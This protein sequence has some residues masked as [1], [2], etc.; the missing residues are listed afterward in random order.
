MKNIART[1]IIAS[2]SAASLLTNVN[3]QEAAV[4]DT[5]AVESKGGFLWGTVMYLPNRIFD[6]QDMVRARVRV[7]PGMTASVRA[8]KLANA[9]VGSHFTAFAGLP[10]PRNKP[11]VN[12]PVGLDNYTGIEASV[13]NLSNNNNSPLSPTYGTTEFGAGFQAAVV[14]LDVGV[15]PLEIVDF[16][17]GIFLIDIKGDDF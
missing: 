2:L 1:V 15:D 6:I 7:G 17:F 9:S 13:V 16:V 5:A 12:L 3:A 14:G 10:G 8:T 4:T 11:S